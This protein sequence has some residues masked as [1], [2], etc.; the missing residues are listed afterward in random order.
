MKPFRDLQNVRKK[1]IYIY[2]YE[3]SNYCRIF[4]LIATLWYINGK[5]IQFENTQINKYK[6][7]LV[8]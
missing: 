1:T 4:I 2:V 6:I 3:V 7:N 8:R 5:A